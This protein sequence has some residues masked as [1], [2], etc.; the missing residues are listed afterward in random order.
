MCPV[1]VKSPVDTVNV[2]T[3]FRLPLTVN[4]GIVTGPTNNEFDP[5][6]IVIVSVIVVLL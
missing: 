2:S 4:V 5:E 3:I 1:I 6:G